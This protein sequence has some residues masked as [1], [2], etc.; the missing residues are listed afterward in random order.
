MDSH[1]HRHYEHTVALPHYNLVIPLSAGDHALLV[2]T[3]NALYNQPILPGIDGHE[4][5][6]SNGKKQG[7]SRCV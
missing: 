2:K 7:G 5:D 6:L 4:Q 3:D 1:T